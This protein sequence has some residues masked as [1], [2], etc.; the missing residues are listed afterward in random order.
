MTETQP[1]KFAIA[2]VALL[3]A[4]FCSAI[5]FA[6]QQPPVQQIVQRSV[7]ANKRDF[8]AAPY[9]NYKERDRSIKGSKEYQVT[10][11]EGSPYYRLLAVNGRDLSASQTAQEME[12]QRQAEQKRRS[13]SPA[14][15]EKRI[16]NYQRER[17]RDAEMMNQ[18]T[19]AFNFTVTAEH[20]VRGFNVWVLKATPRPGY[21]PPSMETEV[22][23]GMQGEMWIDQRSYQWVRVTAQV[24]H[25]VSIEGF[26]AQ[27][28]PGTR[29]ELEKA[30]V[31]G[32]DVW[33]PSH[34]AERANARV[35]MM[36]NHREQEE[37][38][39]WDY[40]PAKN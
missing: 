27:V 7:A 38:W 13:E 4:L 28:E 1:A 12:K 6:Q 11:I 36:F 18:L 39:F 23:T 40:K 16:A 31:A 29:F 22:L 30:P 14:D 34:F 24:I 5:L 9:F 2:L 33:E 19:E 35:L 20:R 10:M 32:S 37:N 26:L 15:R 25:P 17:R 21:R 8:D 3:S